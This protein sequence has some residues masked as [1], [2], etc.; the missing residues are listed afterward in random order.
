MRS[1]IRVHGGPAVRLA[2][3]GT[4]AVIGLSGD[5][6]RPGPAEGEG[7]GGASASPVPATSPRGPPR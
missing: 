5:R 6:G 2:L 3:L 4:L 7:R 1:W